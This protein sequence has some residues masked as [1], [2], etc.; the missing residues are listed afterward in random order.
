MH[1]EGRVPR[2]AQP[3]ALPR[4]VR[5][6]TGG[7]CRPRQRHAH[8]QRGRPDRTFTNRWL[9]QAPRHLAAPALLDSLL[10]L[11]HFQG[12]ARSRATSRLTSRC[13]GRRWTPTWFQYKLRARRAARM[14]PID[15]S[16]GRG[17]ARWALTVHALGARRSSRDLLTSSDAPPGPW[18]RGRAA[19]AV[20]RNQTLSP[21]GYEA[22]LFRSATPGWRTAAGRWVGRAS[23]QSTRLRCCRRS[24]SWQLPG[25]RR[26]EVGTR[27]ATRSGRRVS[28][29]ATRCANGTLT[30]SWRGQRWALR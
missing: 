15:G 11:L 26:R 17:A 22:A 16:F 5:G 29:R 10:H 25:A 1:A 18:W 12:G 28:P 14:A 27:R 7:G 24:P 21:E 9:G 6:S 8:R 19:A 20:V 30:S 3:D 13:A 2:R 4:R 23:C